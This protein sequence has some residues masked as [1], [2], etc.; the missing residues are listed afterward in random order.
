MNTINQ[1]DVEQMAL[2]WLVAV[3]RMHV[4]EVGPYDA[5]PLSLNEA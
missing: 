2:L 5:T 1:D 3:R 4:A